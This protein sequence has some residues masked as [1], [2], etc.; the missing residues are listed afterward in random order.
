MVEKIKS[1]KRRKILVTGSS[2]MLGSAL[3]AGLSKNY[4]IVRFDI[5]TSREHD[6]TD[7]EKTFEALAS[8]KP[9]LIIHAAAWTDVDGCE[10]EP[11]KALRINAG[12]TSNVAAAASKLSIPLIYISTDFIFDGAKKTPYTEDDPPSPLSVYAKSKLEGEKAVSALDKYMILRTS[13]LFGVNGRNFVDIVLN[14]AKE[15]KEMQVV[16][17]QIGSPTYAKDLT[18]AIE[19]L[20]SIKASQGVFHVSNKGAVSWFD[21]AREI[22]RV[23]DVANVSVVPIKASRLGRPAARPA[24]SA[25]DNSKFEKKTGFKMRPWEEALEEYI[26]EKK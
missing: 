13:W 18:V 10:R 25:L 21:Y 4:G 1:E 5:R 20:L 15:E 9:E 17:D 2:G 8:A 24:F 22:L 26:S 6:I 19:K 11:D 16:N 12:G 14:K 23:A 3:S 7:H